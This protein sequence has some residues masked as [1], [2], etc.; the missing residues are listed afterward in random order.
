MVVAKR[1]EDVK[2]AEKRLEIF[3]KEVSAG[4]Y[5]GKSEQ[6][7]ARIEQ[8]LR[9]SVEMAEAS[10]S[11][12]PFEKWRIG[13]V[14]YDWAGWKGHKR[15]VNWTL[16]RLDSPPYRIYI[17]DMRQIFKEIHR[18][19]NMVP[20]IPN[21]E[22]SAPG[23]SMDLV[24]LA[25]CFFSPDTPKIKLLSEGRAVVNEQ[26]ATLEVRLPFEASKTTY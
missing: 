7:K 8:G 22:S 14:A 18:V 1:Q 24:T 12:E 17:A 16:V 26:V 9:L 2:A 3:E 21:G 23:L 13:T 6:D 20:S 4:I 25:H 19:T 15:T 11:Q 10:L 5:A